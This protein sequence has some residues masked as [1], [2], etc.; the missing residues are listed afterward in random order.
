M[1][2]IDLPDEVLSE[3]LAPALK[4]DDEIFSNTADEVSPFATYTESASAYLLVNK[5][6]L[7]VATPL[8]YGTVVLRSKAQAQALERALSGNPVLGPFIKR[9]R[10]EGGYGVSMHRVLKLSPKISHL[11]LSLVIH[12]GDSTDGLCK[13]LSL[14]SPTHFILQDKHYGAP[15]KNKMVRNLLDAIIKAIPGWKRLLYF[16][17]PYTVRHWEDPSNGRWKLIADPLLQARRLQTVSVELLSDAVELYKTFKSCPLQSIV[18]KQTVSR[19]ELEP[20]VDDDGNERLDPALR[21]LLRYKVYKALDWQNSTPSAVAVAP[22]P[23]PFYKPMDNAPEEVQDHIW[24]RILHFALNVDDVGRVQRRENEPGEFPQAWRLFETRVDVLTVSPRFQRLGLPHLCVHV[25]LSE[26]QSLDGFK[27]LLSRNPHL[28]S[29][30]RTMIVGMEDYRKGVAQYQAALHEILSGV[31]HLRYLSSVPS[32]ILYEVYEQTELAIAWKTFVAVDY[33]ELE[34]C[35]IRVDTQKL[36]SAAVFSRFANLRLLHWRCETSFDLTSPAVDVDAFPKLEE[37]L[38][39]ES[40]SSFGI[41]LSRMKLPA[42]TRIRF[43]H[44]INAESLLSLHGSKLSTLEIPGPALPALATNILDLCPNLRSLTVCWAYE[45]MQSSSRQANVRPPDRKAFE[46]RRPV[47]SLVELVFE[48]ANDPIDPIE[49]SQSSLDNWA[50]FLASSFP[51]ESL[52]VLKEIHVKAFKWPT[53]ERDIA[54]SALVTAAETLASENI[55]LRDKE[56]KTWRPRLKLDKSEGGGARGKGASAAAP[57][58]RATRSS[59]RAG[60]SK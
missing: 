40:D 48:T 19:F 6:W 10:V 37:L 24:S 42:L 33:G 22:P 60:G 1:A 29:S 7:R 27:K 17:C 46:C 13:G 55:T 21:A 34:H 3:I 57:S 39:R 47:T 54:K 44:E 53:T 32:R 45:L 8:L 25:V 4:V 38:V 36:A 59:T 43:L 58:G 16:H 23:N 9:L 52:P 50:Q 56:G 12:S 28:K 11:Y 2:D 18:I 15:V 35:S 49:L 14:I 20:E 51:H 30:I 31:E 26:K 5:A 41:L